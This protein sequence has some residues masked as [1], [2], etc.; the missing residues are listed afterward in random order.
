MALLKARMILPFL[1]LLLKEFPKYQ[2]CRPMSGNLADEGAEHCLAKERFFSRK[3]FYLI[4][5]WRVKG[6]G[7]NKKLV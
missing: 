4:M 6:K 1:Q 2:G 7:M 3:C 5:K